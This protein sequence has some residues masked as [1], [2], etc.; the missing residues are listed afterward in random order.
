[1]LFTKTEGFLQLVREFS[2]RNLKLAY[3]MKENFLL[4]SVM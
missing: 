3:I 2:T 1:M 4:P